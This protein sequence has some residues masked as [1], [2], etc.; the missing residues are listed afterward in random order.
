MTDACDDDLGVAC[1]LYSTTLGETAMTNITACRCDAGYYWH[2]ESATCIL[3]SVGYY[4]PA[5]SNTRIECPLSSVSDAGAIS[6]DGCI[7]DQGI[8]LASPN[9][10]NDTMDANY[11]VQAH[12]MLARLLNAIHVP[13]VFGARVYILNH[14]T[15][16]VIVS[17]MVLMVCYIGGNRTQSYAYA[18]PT[19]SVSLNNSGDITDCYAIAGAYRVNQTTFALCLPGFYCSGNVMFD[20]ID[21]VR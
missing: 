11:N 14:I 10:C 17:L 13:L 21:R 3:C 20:T 7:C 16:L 12:G 6:L 4:C 8:S 1:P 9:S 19:R 5:A 2:N 15:R 18:C